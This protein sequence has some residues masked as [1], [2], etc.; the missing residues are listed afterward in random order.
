MFDTGLSVV[1]SIFGGAIMAAAT[2]AHLYLQGKITGVSGMLYK[3]IKR[4]ELNYSA[5]FICGMVFMSSLI[6]VFYN[7]FS[8]AKKNNDSSFMETPANYSKD[9]S[10]FG[11]IV[12]GFLVGF[13][14]RM[15]NGCTSGHG[16]CGIPRLSKRSIVAICLFMVFGGCIATI[17]YYCPFFIPGSYSVQARE[18]S[19]IN[20][21]VFLASLA[22]FGYFL[23]ES[24]KSNAVDKLRDT[25]IAFAVGAAFSFGLMESG[26]LKRHTVVGFL[27]LGTVWNF[28]LIFVLG[29]AVGINYFTFDYILKK[30]K[31][32]LFKSKYDLPTSSTVD[33]KLMVGASIF[34]I[35]WGIGGI[36]PGPA[37]LTS[38]VYFPHSYLFL[39]ALCGGIYVESMYDSKITDIVNK[40]AILSK[41]NVFNDIKIKGVKLN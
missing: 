14:S 4:I 33:N 26:M 40:N 10:L 27:T 19:I 16:I 1:N 36:C 37:I 2:S 15:G 5:S 38:Y 17:R 9:L 21:I 18:L 29:S 34:G 13:G 31:K 30:L 35:G 22:G 41:I 7:P 39:A 32:P 6:N 12:A 24:Y 28:R 23:F 25:G 3:C 11:F 20:I 8:K